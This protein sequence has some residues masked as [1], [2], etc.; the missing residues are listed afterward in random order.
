MVTDREKPLRG[1]CRGGFRIL[2]IL[3]ADFLGRRGVHDYR[4][5]NHRL[6]PVQR[7]PDA[8]TRRGQIPGHH[9]RADGQRLPRHLPD[10]AAVRR[11]GQCAVCQV[12]AILSARAAGSD[13]GRT[14]AAQQEVEP[15]L[16]IITFTPATATKVP[17][18][19][20][21]PTM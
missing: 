6:Q 18:T 17:D 5:G 11:A 9:R 4:G 16:L 21:Q 20:N 1:N 8:Q 2:T 12:N 10:A 14:R 15:C 19:I 13:A 3:R 7:P